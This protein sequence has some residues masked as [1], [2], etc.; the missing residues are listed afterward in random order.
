MK[1]ASHVA[2]AAVQTPAFAM[3]LTPYITVR[4][5]GVGEAM[6]QC[7]LL[8]SATTGGTGGTC[9]WVT[10]MPCSPATR[11]IRPVPTP[12]TLEVLDARGERLA[13]GEDNK[14]GRVNNN[15]MLMELTQDAWL[16]FAPGDLVYVETTQPVRARVTSQKEMVLSKAIPGQA[17]EELHLMNETRQWTLFLEL[18]GS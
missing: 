18:E 13:L 15:S 6:S 9:G 14:T 1:D 11:F 10:W 17:N 16:A 5:I 3:S 4:I 7:V 8:P 2:V 12:W